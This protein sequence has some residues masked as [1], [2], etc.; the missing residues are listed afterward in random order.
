[1]EQERRPIPPSGPRGFTLIGDVLAEANMQRWLTVG[2]ARRALRALCAD[3]DTD[4]ERYR[5]ETIER[6][7]EQ[8]EGGRE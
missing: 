5:Q 8:Q 1:M 2:D 3:A 4:R 7:Q 6:A